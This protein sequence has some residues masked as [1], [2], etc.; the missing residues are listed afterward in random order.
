MSIASEIANGEICARCLMPFVK[1]HGH[2]VVCRDCF[3]A[4]I[5]PKA[6]HRLMT[7]KDGAA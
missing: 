1:E 3:G 6:T 5:G 4:A 7:P 2:P